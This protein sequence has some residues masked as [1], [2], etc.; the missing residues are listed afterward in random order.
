MK[1][2]AVSSYCTLKKANTGTRRQNKKAL[3]KATSTLIHPAQPS[4]PTAHK[5][6]LYFLSR[7]QLL[8]IIS[9]QWSHMP[10][11]QWCITRNETEIS[12]LVRD[13]LLPEHICCR[14]F[15]CSDGFVYSST[16]EHC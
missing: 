12:A 2:S 5:A 1:E 3:L 6:F 10:S 14:T 4:H 16:A 15:G 9:K 13:F 8:S 11:G 7:V